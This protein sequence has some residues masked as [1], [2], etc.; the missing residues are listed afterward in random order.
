[1]DENIIVKDLSA[2][3]PKELAEEII[4]VLDVRKAGSVRLLRVSDQT[5]IADFF[6][7]CQGNS[8]TQVKGLC[9]EVDYR[10]GLDGV[11][12]LRVEGHDSAS[13]ILMDYGSV[14]VHIFQK[15]ARSFYNLE[16]LWGDSEEIDI[17]G[18]LL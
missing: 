3:E 17:S 5:V 10:I 9:D 6:V 1:M 12:P 15:E 8:N 4:H 11:S 7:I 2:A 16:K 14:L 13:W 18:L